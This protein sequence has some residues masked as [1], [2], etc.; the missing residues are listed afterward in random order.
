M[1]RT[2]IVSWTFKFQ[3][4]TTGVP[5]K[6]KKKWVL[7]RSPQNLGE[8][9]EWLRAMGYRPEDVAVYDMKTESEYGHSTFY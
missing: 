3:C 2:D 9:L 6:G 4:A 7:A 1:E 5:K 8:M